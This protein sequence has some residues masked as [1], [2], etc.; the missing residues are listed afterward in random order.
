MCF[1][2]CHWDEYSAIWPY[3]PYHPS[4]EEKP[5]VPLNPTH[6]QVQAEREMGEYGY[7]PPRPRATPPLMPK[8][9]KSRISLE[10]NEQA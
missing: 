5:W 2:G 1:Y 9:E 7:R 10:L 3:C 4:P 6:E 8:P